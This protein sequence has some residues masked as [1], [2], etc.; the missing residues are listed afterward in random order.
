MSDGFPEK[1]DMFSKELVMFCYE[2]RIAREICWAG[3]GFQIWI[4]LINPLD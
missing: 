1:R 4:Q 2:E 3:F